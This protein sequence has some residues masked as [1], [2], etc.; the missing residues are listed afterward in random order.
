MTYHEMERLT[1]ELRAMTAIIARMAHASF[2]QQLIQSELGV[3]P[4]QFAVIH[5]LCHRK[6]TISELS[7]KFVVDPSTLV[8]VV[9]TLERK[10]LV[11]RGR[12]PQDR[13][14][15]PLSLTEAGA[16]LLHREIPLQ[17]DDPVYTALVTLGPERARQLTDLLRDFLRAFPEGETIL[18]EVQSRL[19]LVSKPQPSATQD[20]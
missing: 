7:R 1:R 13:R 17:G 16:E 8:P 18:H 4:M 6:H 2:E 3:S 14:R 12:D 11:E 19:D 10:G 20:V 15:V 9:D 5:S